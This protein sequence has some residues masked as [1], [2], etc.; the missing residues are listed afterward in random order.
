[1]GMNNYPSPRTK[2]VNSILR[3]IDRIRNARRILN[4]EDMGD[5][6]SCFNTFYI[7]QLML[8]I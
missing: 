4:F 2:A 3:V 8:P 5:G 7:T 1:M 6:E